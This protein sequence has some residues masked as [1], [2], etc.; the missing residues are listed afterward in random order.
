MVGDTCATPPGKSTSPVLCAKP[1][2]LPQVD[3]KHAAAWLSGDVDDEDH[4]E[5]DGEGKEG[6]AP[7]DP[8]A[9]DWAAYDALIQSRDGSPFKD[10]VDHSGR[11]LGE[12]RPFITQDGVYA[13]A[14]VCHLKGHAKCSRLRK[15][16]ANGEPIDHVERVLA[17]W[18]QD[19][20]KKKM[21]K[22]HMKMPRL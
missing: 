8:A 10:V 22:T 14:A 7:H 13:C 5:S 6:P 18:L 21:T 12:L 2:R 1:E 15:F 9:R 3:V 17:A 16:R 11:V 19:G 20:T 4:E